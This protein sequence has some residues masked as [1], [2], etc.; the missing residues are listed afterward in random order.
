MIVRMLEFSLRLS[1]VAKKSS[2][3]KVTHNSCKAQRP[4]IWKE[5]VCPG[6]LVRSD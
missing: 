6:G 5:L 2:S 3:G 1:Q 4:D